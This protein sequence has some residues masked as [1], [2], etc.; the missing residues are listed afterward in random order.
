MTQ[1][2]T[3]H[4]FIPVLVAAAIVVAAG[5][6]SGGP[7][8]PKIFTVSGSVAAPG[9]KSMMTLPSADAT[10]P[11]D[12]STVPWA[13]VPG[14]SGTRRNGGSEG[15]GVGVPVPTT[16]DVAVGTAVSVLVGDG[17]ALA[18]AVGEAFVVVSV[19]CG[20]GEGAAT[21]GV[22]VGAIVGA[23]VALSVGVADGGTDVAGA[24]D[25]CAD[26]RFGG[27]RSIAG[28]W[29]ADA[30]QAATAS[31]R[32]RPQRSRR[33]LRTELLPLTGVAR[34]WDGV[35]RTGASFLPSQ[36]RGDG[37]LPGACRGTNSRMRPPGLLLPAL[38]TGRSVPRSRDHA[39]AR[40]GVSRRR[41]RLWGI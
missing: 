39:L 36:A 7:P 34:V 30:A 18:V 33:R 1:R 20:E 40:R 24:G 13:T 37:V 21:V 2:P 38:T 5:C 19:A 27:A 41:G 35:R 15:M 29:Y 11:P 14:A 26:A 4:R 8:K 23:G 22:G 25:D 17:L 28:N 6:G 12:A 32:P 10:R 31:A 16:V 3:Y 9:G